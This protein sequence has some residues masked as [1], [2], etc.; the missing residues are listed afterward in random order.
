MKNV[1]LIPGLLN[2]AALY[3]EVARD[4]SPYYNILNADHTK[5]ETISEV[6]QD[7]LQNAPEKFILGGLSMGGYAAME[8]M[9]QQ[10]ERVEGLILMNTSARADTPAQTE[11]RKAFMKISEIG[12]FRGVT[13]H[14]LPNLLDASNLDDSLIAGVIFDMAR[15][16]GRDGFIRQQKAII[17][18]IDSRVSLRRVTVPTCVIV[19]DNDKLT[20]PDRAKEMAGLIAGAELHI[21]PECG[22]LSPLE[23][24]DEV[25]Q[26]LHDFIARI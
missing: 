5:Y 19:G 13:K 26:I 25:T 24:P 15:E 21:I 17:R 7:I 11:R 9:R 16:V 10:P 6:A 2:T 12:R 4:L 1:L 18:R 3:A 22:H 20:P 23:R 14:L 8:I